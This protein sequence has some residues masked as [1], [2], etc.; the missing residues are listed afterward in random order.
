MPGYRLLLHEKVFLSKRKN[1]EASVLLKLA[2][3]YNISKEQIKA[4]A[5]L[6]ASAV[7]GLDPENVT[8]VDTAGNLLSDL[9]YEDELS[10]FNQRLT[11]TQFELQ[12][13]LS[14]QIR[15]DLIRLLSRVLGPDNF[16]VHVKVK[17][18]FDQ[19]EVES[20]LFHQW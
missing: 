15:N 5:R 13:Q 7:P 17:L 18:N 19:R 16:T 9:I 6:V 2:P 3:N 12:N 20:K 4:I 11:L 8:I 14:N 1:A 10:V